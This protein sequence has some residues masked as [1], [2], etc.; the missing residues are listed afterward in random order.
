[1][2]RSYTVNKNISKFILAMD[3]KPSAVADRAGIRRDVF[4]RI[5]N[6]KRPVYADEVMPIATAMGICVEALFAEEAGE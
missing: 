5:I 1:M 6:C 3:K 4:S 2:E